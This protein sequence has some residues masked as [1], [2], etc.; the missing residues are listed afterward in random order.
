MPQLRNRTKNPKSKSNEQ[1][2]FNLARGASYIGTSKPTL[3]R[4]LRDGLIPHARYGKRVFI[5]KQALDSFMRGE[6]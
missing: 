1:G 5:S 3:S 6:K 2:G 4:M